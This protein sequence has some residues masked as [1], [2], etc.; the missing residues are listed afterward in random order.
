M[1]VGLPDRGQVLVNARN[2]ALLDRASKRNTGFVLLLLL[3]WREF[4]FFVVIVDLVNGDVVD[5]PLVRLVRVVRLSGALLDRRCL[6]R[7][8]FNA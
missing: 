3:L 8:L 6:V 5:A 2:I 7:L 1:P 4:L